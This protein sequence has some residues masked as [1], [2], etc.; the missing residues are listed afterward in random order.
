M[1]EKR[2]SRFNDG[3]YRRVHTVTVHCAKATISSNSIMF[4]FHCVTAA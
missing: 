1:I 4:Y 3:N 2:N